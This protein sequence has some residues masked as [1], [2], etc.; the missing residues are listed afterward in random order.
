MTDILDKITT[1]KRLEVEQSKIELPIE[2]LR[3]DVDALPSRE[4]RRFEKALADTSRVNIIAELKKGSPSQGIMVEEFEPRSLAVRYREGGAA[5]LSV[6]TDRKFFFG[7]FENLSSAREAAV[8]PVLC[9]DFI[10]DP[11]QLLLARYHGADAVLLIARLHSD[12]TLRGLIA[13]AHELGLDCLVETHAADE[14][15]LALDCGARI[16]GVNNRNLADFSIDLAVS[17][18]LA[19]F[20]PTDVIKVTE[21]GL[22]RPEHIARL[23]RAG[24]NCFLIGQALVQAEDPVA[25]LKSIRSA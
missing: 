7:S 11:Y 21:S 14:V 5:A 22:S 10:L 25:L 1:A 20:I 8:L 4:A 16:I 3:R 13:G 2:K 24:F 9:K 23:K 17:E 6:L 15:S 12:A 19:E 18:R